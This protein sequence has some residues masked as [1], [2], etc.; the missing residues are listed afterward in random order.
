MRKR[1]EKK[2]SFSVYKSL[3]FGNKKTYLYVRKQGY[4]SMVMPSILL[5]DKKAVFFLFPQAESKNPHL[6]TVIHSFL[7]L[8]PEVCGKLLVLHGNLWGHGQ[9]NIEKGHQILQNIRWLNQ[10]KGELRCPL[11]NTLF[12]LACFVKTPIILFGSLKILWTIPRHG[13]SP[14][15]R[16]IP[17]FSA[18]TA[19][20]RCMSM[21]RTEL[22]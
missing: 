4:F 6:Y 7:R 18:L 20:S 3:M 19:E 22:A 5:V 2:R 21:A 13:W 10:S 1:E 8:S 16:V 12:K 14:A 9:I 15:R 17:I 11:S